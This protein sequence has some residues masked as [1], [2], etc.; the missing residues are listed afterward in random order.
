M[1][2]E[3]SD[4]LIDVTIDFLD[5]NLD[6][7]L[8]TDG[9]SLTRDWITALKKEDGF[10]EL[11]TALQALQQELTSRA[12]QASRV[13][14]LVNKLGELTARAIP[15]AAD[16]YYSALNDLVRALTSFGQRLSTEQP[17]SINKHNS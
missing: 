3:H 10:D 15:E 17:L 11:I 4:K 12:P 8:P 14:T 2:Q 6:T 9:A 1:V 13:R 16:T 7:A 5:G